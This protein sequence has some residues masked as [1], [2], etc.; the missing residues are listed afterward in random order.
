MRFTPTQAALAVVMAAG[1]VAGT[2]GCG[3]TAKTVAAPSEASR[4]ATIASTSSTVPSATGAPSA[5]RTDL[6]ADAAV[7]QKL[8]A[9]FIAFRSNAANTPGFA[10]IP[11]PAVAGISPGKLFYAFDPATS[12]YWAVATIKAT[13]AA[14]HTSA[15]VGFQDGGSQ[16]VFTQPSGEPWLVK[17]V[18]PCLAGLPNTVAATLA[19]TVSPSPLCPHGAPAG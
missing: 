12:T 2:A 14:S 15:Y 13:E 9:A 11:P 10:S 1:V 16:A 6:V 5:E 17:S 7:R 4:P 3:P 19:L 8:L 18:G